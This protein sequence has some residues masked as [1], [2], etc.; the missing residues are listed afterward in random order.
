MGIEQLANNDYERAVSRGFW[1]NILNWLTRTD[2]RLLPFDE[3]RARLPM[4]GQFYRGIQQVEIEKI[5]GSF[6]RYQDFNRVFLPTQRRTKDRWISI[7]KAHYKQ[8]PLPPVELFKIV[9]STSMMVSE[10]RTGSI[11]LLL[12]VSNPI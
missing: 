1:R 3:V 12:I 2:N 7:N 11:S 5:V 6:G 9:A 4:S 10:P 8:V